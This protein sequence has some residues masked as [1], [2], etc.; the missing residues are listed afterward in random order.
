MSWRFSFNGCSQHQPW[1]GSVRYH[2]VPHQVQKHY[3]ELQKG[4]CPFTS[5]LTAAIF[6]RN[7]LWHNGVCK[8][9]SLIWG[10]V[11]YGNRWSP[12]LKNAADLILSQRINLFNLYKKRKERTIRL[13][14]QWVKL[15]CFSNNG[16]N[17]ANP[18]QNNVSSLFFLTAEV[19]NI[20]QNVQVS[21]TSLDFCQWNPKLS[22][23]PP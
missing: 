5:P 11:S 9:K 4:I 8:G 2:L 20:T 1:K 7:M 6:E 14:R 18:S 19:L 12:R 10:L 21:F 15:L 22:G 17:A 16:I 13:S 3:E 23:I